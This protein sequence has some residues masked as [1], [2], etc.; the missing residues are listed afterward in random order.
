MKLRAQ[1]VI[2]FPVACD[3]VGS[4]TIREIGAADAPKQQTFKDPRASLQAFPVNWLAA[5]E[6]KD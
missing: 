2:N 1:P 6:W 4:A 5:V 3:P